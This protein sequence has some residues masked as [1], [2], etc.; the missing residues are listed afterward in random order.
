MVLVLGLSL[1]PISCS[2]VLPGGTRAAK[3]SPAGNADV[4]PSAIWSELL[5]KTTFPHTAP[6][7]PQRPTILD[8]TYS[9]FDPLER[10]PVA[11]RRCPDYVP[12]G[13]N[14]K[15]N[16]GNGVFRIMHEFTGWRS[17]GSFV[18]DGNRMRLFNDPTCIEV[19]GAYFWALK[20]GRLEFQVIQDECAI[21]MRARNL[22]K[23]VWL[24]GQA[25]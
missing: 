11:C 2:S 4:S 16:F 7:P 3:P 23:Q 21:G 8:G 24:S 18:S 1:N 22:T 13:G 6:L 5:K 25:P 10:A 9:K 14:W 19:T 20:D 17:I 12:A 15:L